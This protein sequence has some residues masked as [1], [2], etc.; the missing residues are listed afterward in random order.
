[1]DKRA[2]GNFL[3]ELMARLQ[4]CRTAPAINYRAYAKWMEAGNAMV[5][6]KGVQPRRQ[7]GF[8]E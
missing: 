7:E 2:S 8:G 4:G 1:M 3:L 6:K 5:R